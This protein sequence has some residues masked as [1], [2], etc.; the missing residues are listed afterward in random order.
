MTKPHGVVPSPVLFES[1]ADRLR[2]SVRY[3]LSNQ[4]QVISISLGWLP[5]SGLR[6]AIQQAVLNNVIVIAAAGNY[7]GR[8]VVWPAA[9]PETVAMAACNAQ[10]EPWWGSARGS[11]VDATGPGQDVWVADVSQ[12][13]A[14]SS[15]TSHAVA[16]VAGIAA[17]WLAHHGR[18]NLLARY[19]GGPTL[20]EVFRRVLRESCQPWNQDRNLWG[21]GIVNALQCLQAPLPERPELAPAAA[22]AVRPETAAAERFEAAFPAMPTPELHERLARVLGVDRAAV[23]DIVEEHGRELRFW[24]LTQP[25]L[26]RALA[27]AFLAPMTPRVMPE[28]SPVLPR[29]SRGLSQALENARG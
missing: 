25:G 15:G 29:F 10:R 27:E 1:G 4:C 22:M 3:A 28:S 16:T 8:V 21:A 5:N 19:Q 12:Y 14:P 24:A 18:D 2:D 7:T 26:R 9:Y 20:A 13:V 17:L 6:R 11:A 23:P